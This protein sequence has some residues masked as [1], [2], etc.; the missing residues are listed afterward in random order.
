VAAPF[1]TAAW[2]ILDI[3]ERFIFYSEGIQHED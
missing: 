3:K 2:M 1:P